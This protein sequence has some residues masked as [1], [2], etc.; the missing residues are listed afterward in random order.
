MMAQIASQKPTEFTLELM[1]SMP[2]VTQEGRPLKQGLIYSLNHV[3]LF[4][5][6]RTTIEQLHGGGDYSLRVLNSV[7]KQ[8]HSMNFS[9]EGD[10]IITEADARV[11]PRFGPR[12]SPAGMI[13]G[14]SFLGGVRRGGGPSYLDG[15]LDEKDQALVDAKK[16]ELIEMQ[17]TATM[18]AR[19]Q[20]INAERELSKTQNKEADDQARKEGE[21]RERREGQELRVRETEMRKE[22]RESST[23]EKLLLALLAKPAEAPRQNGPDL[24]VMMKPIEM[25]M[26]Q[27]TQI[28]TALANKPAEKPAFDV[29]L[30]LKMSSDANDKIVQM[31][32]SSATAAS[33]RHEK[34][35][36]TLL[37]RKIDEGDSSNK[38]LQTIELI[39]KI[40]DGGEGGGDDW[41]NPDA[42][43][44]SNL[45]N[46]LLTG[47]KSLLSNPQTMQMAMG[48][49]NSKLGKPASNT[50]FT[51]AELTP[52]VQEMERLKAVSG[53]GAAPMAALP[54][55]Q[56]RLS[57]QQ[58]PQQQMR[59]ATQGPRF[60]SPVSLVDDPMFEVKPPD[61]QAA[62][63][64]A[65]VAPPLVP[66]AAAEPPMVEITQMTADIPLQPQIELEPAETGDP[67]VNDTIETMLEDVEAYRRVHNWAQQAF[68]KWP[69]ALLDELCGAP[70]DP[71]RWLILQRESDPVIYNELVAKLL[72]DTADAKEQFRVWTVTLHELMQ[73][74][75]ESAHVAA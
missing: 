22:E 6:V 16:Q 14:E 20:R 10:P 1:R 2:A 29:G 43:F 44:L 64:A 13:V 39:D 42:G 62:P 54:P 34:L 35:M 75:T 32:L 8:V 68:E 17:T 19:L 52:V 41:Y 15:P 25:M 53:G 21:A 50:Q 40:R 28:L 58:P 67:E 7:G 30:L 57:V 51:D 74:H 49:L 61:R 71:S 11:A 60:V 33:S 37:T 47:I 59:P 46:G 31:A 24:A 26:A 69:K 9:I 56:G 70:D 4:P 63:R 3:M 27:Q 12:R 66:Q 23:M 55:P 72:V 18:Q 65:V 73:R 48:L 5:H 36:D 38:L 45:G